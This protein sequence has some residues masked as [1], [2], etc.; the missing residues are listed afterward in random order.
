MHKKITGQSLPLQFLLISLLDYSTPSQMIITLNLGALSW[1]TTAAWPGTQTFDISFCFLKKIFRI[2][3][4]L[5]ILNLF[6]ILHTTK[7]NVATNYYVPEGQFCSVFISIRAFQFRISDP[8]EGYNSLFLFSHFPI[9]ELIFMIL[10]FL[11]QI[12][13]IFIFLPCP[14]KKFPTNELML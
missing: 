11:P 10:N 8:C 2:S 7:F 14:C 1:E 12:I 6:K 9:I 5:S 3:S 13:A 4:S